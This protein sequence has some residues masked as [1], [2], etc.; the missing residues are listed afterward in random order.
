M[1][2]QSVKSETFRQKFCFQLKPFNEL[3]V[4]SERLYLVNGLIPRVG[5]TVIWGKPKTGKTFVVSDLVMH[6]AAMS[7]YFKSTNTKELG[8]P[9][10]P[11]VVLVEIRS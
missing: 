4:R 5:T 3:T 2:F 11:I 1:Q 7:P 6:V 9:L 8:H 10:R